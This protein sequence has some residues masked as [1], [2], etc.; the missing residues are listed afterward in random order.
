MRRLAVLVV[1]ALA[2]AAASSQAVAVRGVSHSAEAPASLPIL[3]QGA[4]GPQVRVLQSLLNRRASEVCA[5]WEPCRAAYKVAVDGQFG[6]D[7]AQAVRIFQAQE[8]LARDGIVG[9][10]TWERLHGPRARCEAARLALIAANAS[11]WE[12]EFG[13]KVARRES[14]CSL[15]QVVD[16]PST[17]DYSFGPWGTNYAKS[18]CADRASWLG[19]AWRTTISWPSSARMF[20]KFLRAAGAC[21][22]QKKPSSEH[23]RGYCS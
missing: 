18:C 15:A 16:R 6:P 1:L 20:L 12:V 21:H 23:P 9:P 14:Q 5:I 22:W 11:A 7:T 2:V 19:P 3:K 17:G 10:K 8:L 13:V 4:Q